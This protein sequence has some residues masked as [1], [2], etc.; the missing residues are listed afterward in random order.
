MV[1]RPWSNSAILDSGSQFEVICPSEEDTWKCLET[2][3]AV[4]AGEELLA[5][6]VKAVRAAKHL[7]TH[8]TK[9]YAAHSVYS[10]QIEKSCTDN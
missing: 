3:L 10:A 6:W 2:L 9:N 5:L 7:T 1:C 8:R 4:T